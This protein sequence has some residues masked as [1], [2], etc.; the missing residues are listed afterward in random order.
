MGL[1]ELPPLRDAYDSGL[2]LGLGLERLGLGL[3]L[4]LELASGIA[5]CCDPGLEFGSWSGD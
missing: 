4:G 1:D 2:G 3:G 5:L